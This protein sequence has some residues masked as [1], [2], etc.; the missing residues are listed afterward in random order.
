VGAQTD[1]RTV[2]IVG[3]YLPSLA[4]A[5]ALSK[6]GYR[7]IGGDGGGYRALA[8]SRYCD[9]VWL[10]PPISEKASF[11][12]ALTRFLDTR[13]DITFVLPLLEDYVAALAEDRVPLPNGVVLAMPTPETVSI[14]L[15]KPRM[16]AVAA[17]AGVPHLPLARV[18]DRGSLAATCERVGYPVIIRPAGR[19]RPPDQG[20]LK[21]LICANAAEAMHAFERWH[22]QTDDLFVQRYIRAPYHNVHF[23]ARAGRL[24]AWSESRV[25]RTDRPDGT[26]INVESVTVK[27]DP[28]VTQQMAALLGHLGYTGVG[29]A[30]FLVPPGQDVYFMELN[31][32]LGAGVA[33]P[34]GLGLDLAVA[35][36]ELAG[37]GD[38][39]Q[40]DVRAKDRVGKRFAWT[41]GS[42]KG[43]LNARRRGELTYA[44]ASRWLARTV[45]G[46][47]RADFHA[48]WS[49]RDPA[50]TLVIFT[51]W[52]RRGT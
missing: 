6:A 45:I 32:R 4:V 37:S 34:Q 52:L 14:C 36:C 8:S 31:P 9:E 46:A 21:A 11:F 33:L 24:L 38:A 19:E 3:S 22:E 35:A 44:Q 7:V 47:L 50:P 5:R 26:G 49:V 27:P 18:A 2:L 15:D 10:H 43:L 29:L 13:P 30:Q 1:R 25:L 39:W 48:T 51:S 12:D 16:Y 23:A 41:S 40:P 42:I 20:G 17:R 28:R